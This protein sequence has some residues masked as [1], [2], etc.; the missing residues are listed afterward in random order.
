MTIFQYF[1]CPV[2]S[3]FKQFFIVSSFKKIFY[4]PPEDSELCLTLRQLCTSSVALILGHLETAKWLILEF[5]FAENQNYYPITDLVS[6]RR[7]M[8]TVI[9]AYHSADYTREI[10]HILVL[11]A[12][13]LVE[14]RKYFVGLVTALLWQILHLL[15]S[16]KKH[17]HFIFSENDPFSYLNI[18]S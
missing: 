17:K 11:S 4:P 16:T 2:L 13:K 10:Q 12:L 3:D 18:L 7:P 5:M 9:S 6:G 8:Y 1:I 14:R 15:S